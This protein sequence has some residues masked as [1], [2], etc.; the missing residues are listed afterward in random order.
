M[1]R[2]PLD[3]RKYIY[4]FVIT[5]IIFFT[6]LSISNRL[7]ER[8]MADLRLIQDGIAIDMLSSEVRSALLEEFSCR[9][10]GNTILS[11]ELSF[12]G[13]K[14]MFTENTRGANDPEVMVLKKN[15]SLLQIKDYLLAKRVNEKCGERSVPVIYFYGSGC[16]DCDRQGYVLTKLREDYPDLRV[17]S[18]DYNLE[19]SAMETLIA[20]NKVKNELPALV[21]GDDVYYGFKSIEDMEK[22]I[23]R[24]AIWKAEKEKA[25]ADKAAQSDS[26]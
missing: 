4:A 1:Q 24:I 13:E 18:F 14:L 22:L 26:Q 6:A 2:Q 10:V 19:V 23:P 8:R 12:L 11:R 3:W 21:V 5:A 25:E 9:E 20:I 7:S 15:Y 16:S 17:Y